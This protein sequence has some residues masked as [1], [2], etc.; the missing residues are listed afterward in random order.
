MLRLGPLILRNVLRNRRRSLLTL[1]STAVTV[2][3]PT[4]SVVPVRFVVR[5]APRPTSIRSMPASDHRA[6]P[7]GFPAASAR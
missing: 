7:A 1:A 2:L 5:V 3:S 4:R 6:P